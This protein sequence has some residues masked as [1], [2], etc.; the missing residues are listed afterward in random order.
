MSP[1]EKAEEL[2]EKMGI[3]RIPIT[4]RW[5]LQPNFH[6]LENQFAKECAS[7]CIDE[8]IREIENDRLKYW[9]EVRNE[10]EKL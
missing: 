5:D 6:I 1:K 9:E 2:I 4:T 7:I 3:N 10:F 8:V